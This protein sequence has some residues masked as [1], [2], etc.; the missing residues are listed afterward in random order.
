MAGSIGSI[1][2]DFVARTAGF[3]TGVQTNVNTLRQGA[4]QMNTIFG[5]VSIAGDKMVSVMEKGFLRVAL[6]T[7]AFT[8]LGG[9]VRRVIENI[10]DIPG[11]P[12]TT[13][14][15][16]NTMKDSMREA[17]N[18]L[19]GWIASGLSGFAMFGQALGVTMAKVANGPMSGNIDTDYS[20]LSAL[21]SPDENAAAADL[22]YHEK[23][24]AA[25]EKLTEAR[26]QA[27]LAAQSEGNQIDALLEKE[28]RYETFADSVN[29]NSLQ[30]VEAQTKAFGLSQEAASKLRSLQDQLTAAQYKEGESFDKIASK[31]R[32]TAESLDMLRQAQ[33]NVYMQMAAIPADKANDPVNIEKQIKLTKELTDIQNRLA[34]ALGKMREPMAVMRDSFASAFE[35]MS[36]TLADFFVDGKANM[37]DFFKSFEK[38][39]LDTFLK[40]SLLNPL[41]NSLFGKTAGWSTLPSF[42]NFGGF[43][44]AG[45]RPSVGDVSVVGENGPE[46]FIP[47]T[48]GTVLPNS[49]LRG[50]GGGGMVNYNYQVDARGAD[51]AAVARLEAVLASHIA[52]H[53]RSVVGSVIAE[54]RKGGANGRALVGA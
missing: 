10:D 5:Q 23:L 31:S 15:S 27:G 42:F 47:D 49:A 1:F 17:R 29:L 38:Q 41:L 28:K 45:G 8:L 51:A 4:A 22:G 20:G 48:A 19:D 37:G 3:Q 32:S 36:S 25:V 30:K 14:A 34:V 12:A 44:A 35:G 6:G 50:M 43:F 21:G 54:I 53:S 2:V 16:V 11:I 13:V 39:I 52:T 24:R 40:L 9:E 18:V 33:A 46:L 7:K 26:F